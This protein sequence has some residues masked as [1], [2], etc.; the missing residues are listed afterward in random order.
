MVENND[1]SST[2][3]NNNI[4]PQ[5]QHY[6]AWSIENE[7]ILIKWCDY[8]QCYKW[9]NYQAQQHYSYLHAWF[10][11]ST[12]LLSTTS[13]VISF[14]HPILGISYIPYIVGS[15]NI[16]VGMI[17]AI[18]QYLNISE[19]KESYRVCEVAWGKLSR[20]I[21]IEIAKSPSE[22][23]D[24]TNFFKIT[25]NEYDRLTE[26]NPTIPEHIIKE[27][28][29]NFVGDENSDQRKKY[30][31]LR[32]PDICD[33]IIS[34]S[35]SRHK[36]YKLNDISYNNYNVSSNNALDISKVSLRNILY[37]ISKKYIM[38][39]NKHVSNEHIDL[40]N[41]IVYT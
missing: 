15:I 26:I 18:Q 9:L 10:T 31:E 3:T 29:D 37:D 11:I 20:N 17:S 13:G 5:M 27:F 32:K 25:R 23:M 6:M 35:Y 7:E 41:N 40:E 14:S 16:F 19:L 33:D 1:V 34:A 22:R 2:V 24:A 8:A 4:I 38:D 39:N 28:K 12:I 30:A 36:W 21:L